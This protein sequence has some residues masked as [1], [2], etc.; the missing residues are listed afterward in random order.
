[1]RLQ[2]VGELRVQRSRDLPIRVRKQI[3]ASEVMAIELEKA[4]ISIRRTVSLNEVFVAVTS[5]EPSLR[6][7][8][9][10][11]KVSLGAKVDQMLVCE[12]V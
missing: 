4:S 8:T 7:F 6:V 3:Q 9:V 1:L 2:S 12:V 10:V 11:R 5:N